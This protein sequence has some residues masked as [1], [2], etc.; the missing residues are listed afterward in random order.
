MLGEGK[1]K[2]LPSPANAGSIKKVGAITHVLK[3]VAIRKPA[4]TDGRPLI[5]HQFDDGLFHIL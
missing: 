1:I 4:G 3:H 5:F 2:M